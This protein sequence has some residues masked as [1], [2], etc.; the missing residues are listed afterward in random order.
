MSKVF[1]IL[2]IDGGGARG[3]IPARFLMELEKR[4]GR[5]IYE[6]FDLIAGTS[7]GSI[8]ALGLATPGTDGKPRYC[9]EDALRIYRDEGP[10][11]FSNN[12]RRF[13]L[14]VNGYIRPKYAFQ[15]LEDI[16]K[17]YFGEIRLSQLLRDT[18]ITSYD[19]EKRMPWFFRSSNAKVLPDY[20]FSLV[21][22]IRAATAAPSY[23]SPARLLTAKDELYTLVDGGV[24][25]NNPAMVGYVDALSKYSGYDRIMV[26]SLGTG[27]ADRSFP[28][29]QAQQWG[30]IGWALPA[31]DILQRGVSET[32]D[33]QMRQV[34]NKN[35]E[36][37]AQYYRLQIRLGPNEDVLDDPRP[38]F[39]NQLEHAAQ[40]YISENAQYFAELAAQ[41]LEGEPT[42]S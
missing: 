3:V 41:L 31:V 5:H 35:P 22:V 29:S 1:K 38:E 14:T 28:Y 12:W 23:F 20:D 4:T 21:Q 30:L 37:T 10:R 42:K 27:L 7:T 15:P 13:L 25:A 16:L 8:L 18:I 33:Y 17:H 39:L 40:H 9:A 11:I 32:V 6:L 24:F 34:L 2:A 36:N 19:I 26:V